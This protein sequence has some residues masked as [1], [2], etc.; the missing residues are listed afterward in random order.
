LKDQPTW[1][2]GWRTLAEWSTLDQRL[3]LNHMAQSEWH[4]LRGEA[5][6]G[7]KQ[8]QYASQQQPDIQAGSVSLQKQKALTLLADQAE[9]N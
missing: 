2:I 7:L 1:A 4:L 3:Q 5:E 6:L 9:F 8:A